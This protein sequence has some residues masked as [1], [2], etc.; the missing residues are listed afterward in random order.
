MLKTVL[1]FDEGYIVVFRGREVN[2]FK[3]WFQRVGGKFH[4][5]FGWYIPSNVPFP[6]ITPY[7]LIQ[8]KVNWTDISK[9]DETLKSDKEIENHIEELYEPLLKEW[10]DEIG[11]TGED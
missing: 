11:I 2:T 10:K 7:G 1:G 8:I 4:K 5:I 6:E 3:E 9:N